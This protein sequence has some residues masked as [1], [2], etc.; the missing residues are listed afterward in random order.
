MGD[1]LVVDLAALA[2]ASQALQAI[3]AELSDSDMVIGQ[4][5]AAI[6]STNETQNLRQAVERVSNTWDV[7]RAEL[8]DDVTYL[9]RM[10]ARVAQELGGVDRGLATRLSNSVPARAHASNPTRPI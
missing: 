3:S 6:G 2:E 1:R 7:R 9:S 10:A 4:V 8:R 5:T